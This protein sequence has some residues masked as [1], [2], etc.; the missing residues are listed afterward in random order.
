MAG[1]ASSVKAGHAFVEITMDDTKLVKGLRSAQ[2]QLKTFGEGLT[3]LGTKM[4]MI[5][6][7]VAAPFTYVTKQFADFDDQMLLVQGVTGATDTAMEKLTD[8]AKRLGRETSYTAAQ[9]AQGMVSLGRMG[10]TI[11]EINNSIGNFMNLDRATGMNDLGQSAEIAAAAMRSFGM[12]AQDTGRIADVL[13]ATANGSAQTLTDVGEALKMAA[14]NANMSNHSIEDT[15]A[16]LGVLANLGIKG[17]LAGTALAKSFDR[18][19][20]GDG[21]K[22]LQGKG[23]KTMDAQKNLRPMRDILVDIAK[24]TK[25]MGTGE[26]I[27]F[28]KDVFDIRGVKGGGLLAGQTEQLDKFLAALENSEGVAAKTAAKMDSGIGGAFRILLSAVEGVGNEIGEIIGNYLKPYMETVSKVL[29][30][31]AEWVKEHK[32]LIVTIVKVTAGVLA[33]GAALIAL[34]AAVKVIAFSIGGLIILIKAIS[35]PIFIAIAAVKGLIA[36]F[37][38]LKTAIVALNGI[39]ITFAAIKTAVLA[40]WNAILLSP[41]AA[42]LAFA[43]AVGAIF[44]II[45]KCT[46]AFD[47]LLAS[48]SEFG[49]GCTAAFKTIVDV[50]KQSYEAIKIAFAAGDLAGAAKVGLAALNVVWLAGLMPLK[51]AWQELK[52]FLL[53]AW[54]FCSYSLLKGASNLWYGLLIGLKQ[55]GVGIANTW[56]AIWGG[57]ISAFE[58]TIGYLKKKWIQFKGFFDSD[59]NVDAEIAKVDA[60]IAANK[61]ER[62]KRS[63]DAVN[64]RAGEVNAL[65]S[66]RDQFGNAIDQSM[67]DEMNQHQQSYNQAMSDAAK[68]LAD[69]K[70]QWQTAIDDVKKKAAAGEVKTPEATQAEVAKKISGVTSDADKVTGAWQLADLAGALN[71]TAADRTAAATE[72]SVALQEKT[73]KRLEAIEKKSGSGTIKYS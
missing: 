28:F 35:A 37:T 73:N 58:S 69:A 20:A 5:G 66:E 49:A 67:Y 36:I 2:K 26:K 53:D 34:G 4:T 48:F 10:F 24:V 12:S 32:D 51:K 55:I 21:A 27:A 71:N 61:S 23:I 22:I 14:T 50:A 41:I 54:T 33:A 7:A 46:G 43:A 19:A 8:T 42:V 18:L 40:C 3:G 60:E 47:G 59:V 16:M 44:V 13:T 45:Q 62:A 65:K 29:N 6:A 39:V 15:C 17:S 63:N 38:V 68:S 31:V 56:D 30:R 25:G 9:V 72:K 11:D 1:G 52:L 57:I 64:R 70:T